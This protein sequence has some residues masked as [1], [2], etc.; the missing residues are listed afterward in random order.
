[1][2]LNISHWSILVLSWH[3]NPHIT[4]IRFAYSRLGTLVDEVNNRSQFGM[5]LWNQISGSSLSLDVKFNNAVNDSGIKMND[6]HRS[7]CH[8]HHCTLSAT[9]ISNVARMKTR[10]EN[11]KNLFDLTLLMQ[12]MLR[13]AMSVTLT[14]Q[15]WSFRL[16]IERER[17]HLS[18]GIYFITWTSCDEILSR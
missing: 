16:Q 8:A 18:H 7:S 5:C 9:H 13:M 4:S 2:S 11:S 3:S 12:V 15:M 1:M 6:S 17:A 14:S 10:R